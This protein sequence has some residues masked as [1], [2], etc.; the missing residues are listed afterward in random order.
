MGY[1]IALIVIGGLIWLTV[2]ANQKD[3]EREK[4]DNPL[5]AYYHNSMELYEANRR[6]PLDELKGK[7]VDL[8]NEYNVQPTNG[9]VTEHPYNETLT[10]GE[11]LLRDVDNRRSMKL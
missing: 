4:A 11:Y 7:L 6:I 9:Y 8:A 1:M 3:A 10:Q 5:L 2:K